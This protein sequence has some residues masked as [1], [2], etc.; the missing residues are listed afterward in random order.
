MFKSGFEIF[1]YAKG[2]QHQPSQDTLSSHHWQDAFL[3]HFSVLLSATMAKNPVERPTTTQICHLFQAYAIVL[4]HSVLNNVTQLQNFP[5]HD[6]WIKLDS[7]VSTTAALLLK[8][9]E[10]LEHKGDT[11]TAASILAKMKP[12]RASTDSQQP[13]HAGDM[14][15]RYAESVDSEAS[16]VSAGLG[17]GGLFGRQ[18]MTFERDTIVNHAHFVHDWASSRWPEAGCAEEHSRL[19]RF[20]SKESKAFKNLFDLRFNNQTENAAHWA[21][22]K[23]NL[24]VF[25]TLLDGSGG[26]GWV[27]QVM[28]YKF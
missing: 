19:R 24:I 21:A 23:N 27:N 10:F 5:S 25:Q 17:C 9:A 6:E 12:T 22:G 14:M 18:N 1:N 8:V 7:Q 26:G 3:E 4:N 2:K 28:F 20:L 16:P 13:E 11:Q 15:S